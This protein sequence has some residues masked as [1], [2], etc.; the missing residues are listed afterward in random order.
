MPQLHKGLYQLKSN[1]WSELP[2]EKW[3]LREEQERWKQA[4]QG[5]E[6]G[7]MEN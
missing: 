3:Q 5:G 2:G 7:K 6:G 1:L 4:G